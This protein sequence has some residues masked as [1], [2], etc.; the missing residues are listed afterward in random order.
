[1][2]L[3]NAAAASR[4]G[5]PEFG[6]LAS[7]P[8]FARSCGA[9]SSGSLA[10]GEPH[11]FAG[12]H[13]ALPGAWNAALRLSPLRRHVVP[14][15]GAQV[16]IPPKWRCGTAHPGCP[17]RPTSKRPGHSTPITLATGGAV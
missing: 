17:G 6:R 13:T 5:S 8:M 16:P 12:S 3:G 4:G 2:T 7:K 11:G 14:P 10:F 9:S 15:K 1:M